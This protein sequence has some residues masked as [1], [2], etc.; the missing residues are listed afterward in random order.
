MDKSTINSVIYE[1]LD[2][3]NSTM[4]D[5]ALSIE[6]NSDQPLYGRDGGLDS[7]ALV[8][9]LS[10]IEAKFGHLGYH[11]NLNTDKAFSMARSPFSSIGQLESYILKLLHDA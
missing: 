6:N 9:F 7:M 11:V 2:E 1:T 8:M 4:M 5:G 10:E 3:I